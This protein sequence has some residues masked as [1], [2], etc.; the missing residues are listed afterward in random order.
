MLKRRT[1][2]SREAR[3]AKRDVGRGK[4]EVAA[5]RIRCNVTL[6]CLLTAVLQRHEII[7]APILHNEKPTIT[8]TPINEPVGDANRN[9]IMLSRMQSD[10]FG[11]FS[12]EV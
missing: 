9:F 4:D 5:L 7:V 2:P 8:A 1:A 10:Q 11:A 3:R 12:F 6:P